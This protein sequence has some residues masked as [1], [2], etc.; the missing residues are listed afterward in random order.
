MDAAPRRGSVARSSRRVGPM[1]RS[2]GGEASLAVRDRGLGVASVLPC[3]HEQRSTLGPAASAAG[4]AVGAAA[5]ALAEWDTGPAHK[6]KS[7]LRFRAQRGAG[8][9]CTKLKPRLMF[10]MSEATTTSP[11][12][13]HL[14]EIAAAQDG[15]FT[16]QQAAEA[17]YSPQL[18][19]HL[20]S[21]LA[22]DP[23]PSRTWREA[24]RDGPPPWCSAQARPDPRR[25]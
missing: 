7:S 24:P 22:G 5:R 1:L 6:T 23:P 25:D 20:P 9:A 10:R 16:T 12:W 18:L 4:D 14:F 15:L 13:D 3:R 8:R 11:D 17:G 19:A 21:G 2:D